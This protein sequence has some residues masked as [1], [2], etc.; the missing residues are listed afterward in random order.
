MQDNNESTVNIFDMVKELAGNFEGKSNKDL[1]IAIYKEAK[2]GKQNGTLKNEDIENF[3]QIL[4]P[5][6]EEKQQKVLE[7]I[8]QE[9]KKI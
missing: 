9:L 6:L 3:S 7:K 4:S 5:F 8:V 1:L 2:K